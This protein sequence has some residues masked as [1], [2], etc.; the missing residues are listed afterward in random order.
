MVPRMR[1]KTAHRCEA[2]GAEAP[3]WLGRC[4][5]CGEWGSV[6]RRSR[7]PSSTRAAASGQRA[8]PD[9]R[10]GGDRGRPAGHRR[11]RARPGARRRAR[12]RAR[13]RCSAAS[14]AWA[15]ARCCSR[16][17]ARWPRRARAACSSAPRSRREQVRLRAERLG[18]LAPRPAR[19]WPRRRCPHVLAHVEA[20]RARRARGRLDP[21]RRSIPTLPG[22]PGSVTQ[23]R[24]CAYRL[25]AAGQ[26][27]RRCRRCSSAT[28]PR[29]ARSPGRARSST[30]STPCSRSTATGTTRCASCAR[31]STGSAPRS[32]LGLF[33]MAE[34]RPRRRARRVGAVPRRPARR[35]RR[36]RW[37]R[38]VLEGARPLLVEVQ[39]LVAPTRR[40]PPRRVAAGL[41][42]SAARRCCSRCSSSAPGVDAR[43]RRRVRERRRR[44]AGRRARRRPR[45]RARGRR[46]RAGRRRSPA[47]TVVVG[48]V[49]LGGEVR[50]VAAGRAPRSPKPRGS[51]SRRAVGPRVARPTVPG[52]E[53]VAVR[54]R[55]PTRSRCG[56]GDAVPPRP[57]RSPPRPALTCGYRCPRRRDRRRAGRR[58]ADARTA[59]DPKRCSV[60]L[61]LVAPGTPLREGIERIIQARMGAL[62]VV[63]DGPDVLSVCSGG[64]LLDAE[65]TPQ[66]LSE[67]AKMDGAIILSG[68]CTADRA[69]QRAPRPRPQHP[70][71]RRPAPGTAPPSGSPARSTVPVITISED[72]SRGR[73]PRARRRSARSSRRRACSPGPTRRSRSSSATRPA[74]TP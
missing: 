72:R 22:A 27:A 17:S 34:A 23:V 47:D 38:R 44:R 24:D 1:A 74:S 70:H 50:Q 49:G 59:A 54:R 31:S 36:A 30:S 4:P 43:R 45:G 57:R 25:V 41:D 16:R 14:R 32:E 56:L 12:R 62:I 55:S 28:S 51:A 7:P 33:E 53:V 3:R 19:S 66:R 13:S 39:A 5:G 6:D 26:G 48:E 64:F 29:R 71:R 67:L 73:D 68:D 2:C 8:R 20:R 35:A 52:V 11:R 58:P 21:D 42:A 40:R 69:G 10:R 60:A 9:R 61:R 46:A 18:A 37:S 63:G 65:F 15:R